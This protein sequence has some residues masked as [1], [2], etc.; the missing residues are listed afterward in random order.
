MKIGITCYPTYGGSGVV[1]TELGMA[2][3]RRG[4]E[5]HFVS[6]EAP[7]RLHGYVENVYYHPVEVSGYPLFKYPPYCLALAG[8]MY[9]VAHESGLDMLHVHYA[10]PHALSAHLAREMPGGGSL[11]IVTT[12]HGTDVVLVGADSSYRSVTRYGLK[13]SDGVTAVSEYLKRRTREALQTDCEIEVIPNFVNTDEFAPRK[14]RAGRRRF[15]DA[16]EKIIAHLSNFRPVKRVVDVIE[17]FARIR[18]RM[19]AKLLMVGDGPDRY[20]A[21]RRARELGVYRDVFFLGGRQAVADL[22]APADLFILP[23]EFE[24]FGLAN[25]EAMSCGVPVIST[26]GSGVEEAV[27]NGEQGRLCRVG[28]VEAMAAA[29]VEILTDGNLHEKMKKSARARALEN[30]AQDKI[31]EKYEK[32]YEKTLEK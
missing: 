14:D 18:G 26:L 17:V 6:Y 16:G 21:E 22:L 5:V 31:V 25:L 24:S 12:L 4:H 15:A 30:F 7:V 8:R 32:F 11:K 2:L 3:A 20:K 28:D 1:A 23:S 13:V 29:A 27:V 9:E 10:V 19:P